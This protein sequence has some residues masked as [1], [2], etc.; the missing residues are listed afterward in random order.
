MWHEKFG[1]KY[2][3]FD[4]RNPSE[5][6]IGE[7]EQ[8]KRLIKLVASNQAVLLYGETGCGKTTLARNIA[9]KIENGEIKELKNIKCMYLRCDKDEIKSFSWRYFKYK[10]TSFGRPL[11]VIMDESSF[12]DE[13]EGIKVSAL[14]DDHEIKSFVCVQ[15]NEKAKLDQWEGRIGDDKKIQMRT[16]TASE[17]FEMLKLRQADKKVFD[18]NALRHISLNCNNNPRTS[19]DRCNMIAEELADTS[20]VI[21]LDDV[22]KYNFEVAKAKA[23]AAEP[24]AKKGDKINDLDASPMEKKI[25]GELRISSRTMK[26][27]ASA[28]NTGLNT[29]SS[30]LSKLRRE[31][32]VVIVSKDKPKKYGLNKEFERGLLSD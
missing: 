15:M 16:I 8:E 5:K 23:V 25:I 28:C 6:L 24:V 13:K 14:W 32:K 12:A 21:T 10:L 7:D 30:K 29:I 27:L 19:L 22:K 26:D 4:F 20:K 31:K 17:I 9:R 18:D 1:Y 3:P 11:V 2:D